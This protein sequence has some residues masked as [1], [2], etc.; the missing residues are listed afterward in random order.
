M[1]LLDNVEPMLHY[2]GRVDPVSGNVSR[3]ALDGAM[4]PWPGVQDGIVLTGGVR[5]L[6][7]A[8]KHIDNKPARANGVI[9]NGS[10]FDPLVIDMEL[11]AH[12]N[13]PEGISKVWSEWEAAWDPRVLGKFEWIT[14]DRGYWYI[15]ARLNAPWR[16]QQKIS[17]RITLQ[18]NIT[19]SMRCDLGFWFGMPYCDVFQTLSG[20]GYL[21]LMNIGQEDGWP[22]LTCYG[23]GTFSFGN[24]PSSSTMI[25]LGPLAAGQVALVNTYPPLRGVV[26]VTNTPQTQQLNGVQTLVEFLTNFVTND[27]LPPLAVWFES[28]FGIAPQQQPLYSLLNGRFT[29]PIPG[30]PQTAWAQMS[31][32]PVTITG[33]SSSSRIV[34]RID[35]MRRSPE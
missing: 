19:H 16:D 6:T 12:A 35:P 28:V 9:Y 31:Y 17:P 25:T 34:G 7:S 22:T 27:N 32:I 4:A 20:S 15:P 26:D 14:Q 11:Q 10:I 8:F 29:N 33:G 18:R 2:A 1:R 24:G 3:F 13:S 21:R 30:V 23:P 5:G